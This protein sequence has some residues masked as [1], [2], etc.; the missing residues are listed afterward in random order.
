MTKQ[1]IA[2]TNP[3]FI[4]MEVD[5]DDYELPTGHM[6]DTAREL[7]EQCGVKTATIYQ[8]ISRA[9]RRQMRCRYVR[10]PFDD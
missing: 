4:W 7:A 8:M 9:K 1:E 5:M 10:V 6:A 3:R 2:P